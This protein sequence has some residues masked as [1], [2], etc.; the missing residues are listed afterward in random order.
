M[1]NSKIHGRPVLQP[2]SNR[3]SSAA[4]PNDS[5]KKPLLSEKLSPAPLPPEQAVLKRRNDP[6]GL[7]SSSEKPPASRPPVMVRKKSK[8]EKMTAEAA[9]GSIA[10]AQREKAT[11]LQQQRKLRTAHYG[12][13]AGKLKSERAAG[14]S[15]DP[16]YVA[17]HDD[18]WG[19]PVHD[20][21][22]AFDGFDAEEVAKFT[23]KQINSICSE[24]AME[25]GRVRGVVDNAITILEVTKDFGSLNNYFWGFVNHKSLSP[26]YKT[27]RKIPA[28]T[29]KSESISKDLVRRGFRFGGPTVVHSFMQ[30]AGLTNDHLLSCPRHHQ[31]LSLH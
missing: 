11:L 26:G 6:N 3:F 21:K 19:V 13:T 12:R 29:S 25:Q 10:A 16:L 23:E 24:Y 28:K 7:N 15:G 22:A 8:R 31:L 30:A 2:A 18:E 5:M 4:E 14:D 20:D 1:C 27:S 9:A 17:Y